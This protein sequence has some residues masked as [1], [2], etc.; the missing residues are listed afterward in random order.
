MTH[1]LTTSITATVPI[2][3]WTPMQSFIYYLI[4]L[5][6]LTVWCAIRVRSVLDRHQ[7]SRYF[8]EIDD[9]YELA[10][11]AAGASRTS[12]LAVFR[13]VKLGEIEW[14]ASRRGPLLFGKSPETQQ[15]LSELERHLKNAVKT[16]GKRG[17]PVNQAC[18]K[19]FPS[20]R[21]IEVKLAT[22][23][24]RPT[25]AERKQAGFTAV[26]PLFA[27]LALGALLVLIGLARDQSVLGLCPLLFL[28]IIAMLVIARST[29]R[30]T[31]MGKHVLSQARAKHHRLRQNPSEPP[32]I[33][34]ESLSSGFALFGSSALAGTGDATLIQRHFRPSPQQGNHSHTSYASGCSSGCGSSFTSDTSDDGG[35][36]DSSGSSGCGSS[37]CGGCGG[38]GD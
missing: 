29:G 16:A 17:I 2:W 7:D 4:A 35:G 38:G 28:T 15:A 5:V 20:M 31:L 11:L 37:G 14:L 19:L 32:P 3:D 18:I 25:E 23:G 22:L 33:D 30:L 6:I 8:P 24:L 1:L 21:P 13:L 34:L 27:L 26:M 12:Q 36:G 9:F 10:Y